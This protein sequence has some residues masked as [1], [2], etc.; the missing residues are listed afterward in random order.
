MRQK[1]PR[2]F[3]YAAL[4]CEAKPLIEYFGLKKDTGIQ[5]FA[6][7]SNQDICL[8]VTGIGKNAMAA[9]VAYTQALLAPAAHPALINLGIAGH[10]DHAVGSLFVIDKIIDA[11]SRKSYFPP[12]IFTP[13]C[14]TS[15]IQTFSTPQLSY[16]RQYL[17]D[18]EAA[19]FYETAIRFTSSEL[20]Q[21]V[22]VISDNQASPAEN[23]EP[24]Q[25]TALIAEH[26]ATI[27]NIISELCRLADLLAAPEESK[28][29]AE[30]T[31]R[32]HFTVSERGQLKN[33]L[34]RWTALTD[35]QTLEFDQTRFNKGK[36]VLSWLD[37][38]IDQLKFV[39]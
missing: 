30:L 12:L 37:R 25:A 14:A 39:L 31:Q 24:K 1:P 2:V 26:A 17:C 32:Y 28:L 27:A 6:V 15:G 33:Q 4:A 10:R 9:G 11:D 36:D 20:V 13:P 21:C 8:T 18:M 34:S 23:I 35:N 3:I 16:D 7:F 38:Q 19:A 22:K 29:F 5:P